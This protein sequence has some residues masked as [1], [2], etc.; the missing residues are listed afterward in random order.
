[1]LMN[2]KGD[3]QG[4]CRSIYLETSMT[5]ATFAVKPPCYES[6]TQITSLISFHK[7]AE[8]IL[9]DKHLTFYT[10]PGLANNNS[11]HCE[12]TMRSQS[13]SDTPSS[14]NSFQPTGCTSTTTDV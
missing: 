6:E 1:M 13:A 7:P 3:V 8:S 12:D 2:N 11:G 14:A 5:S 10:L 4:D 9:I